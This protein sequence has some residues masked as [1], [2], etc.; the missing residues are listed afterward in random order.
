MADTIGTVLLIDDNPHGLPARKHVLELQGYRA[1]TAGSGE[2]GLERFEEQPVDCVVT[3]FR[4]PQMTGLEVLKQLRERRPSVPV[5][6][7]SGYAARVGMTRESTGADAVI[8]K[9]PHEESELV[10]T[11]GRLVRK[12]PGRAGL[13]IAQA[14]SGHT[15]G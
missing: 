2:E 5:V 9:G 6:I 13:P 15:M 12:R 11:I 10:R 3:D 8:A 14:A 4:M 7:L 1:I